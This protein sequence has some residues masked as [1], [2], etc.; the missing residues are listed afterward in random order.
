MKISRDRG[1]VWPIDLG[2]AAESDKRKKVQ[3]KLN[4]IAHFVGSKMVL[5][6]N[7]TCLGRGAREFVK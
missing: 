3:G 6:V 5:P 4:A 1:G 7:S 2:L